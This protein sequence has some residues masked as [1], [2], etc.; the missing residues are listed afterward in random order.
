MEGDGVLSFTT[1]DADYPYE[2][3]LTSCAQW[4][5]EHGF[6]GHVLSESTALAVEDILRGAPKRKEL[7]K[8]I[9]KVKNGDC[10]SMQPN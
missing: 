3:V 4:L 2:I 10:P 5:E 6:I 7:R 9:R 1:T 8:L